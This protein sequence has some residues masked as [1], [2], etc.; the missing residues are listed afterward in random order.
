MLPIA[1][2][3]LCWGLPDWAAITKSLG[4]SFGGHSPI[5]RCLTFSCPF[6]LSGDAE[7][8]EGKEIRRDFSLPRERP[9]DRA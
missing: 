5:R 6:L 4:K 9:D 3:G 2:P 8:I 1:G 7:E